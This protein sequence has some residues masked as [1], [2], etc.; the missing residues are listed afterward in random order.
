MTYL[1]ALADE[2]YTFVFQD[3][4]G[5]FGSEGTFE[6]EIVPQRAGGRVEHQGGVECAGA[7]VRMH[8]FCWCPHDD[9]AVVPGEPLLQ[10]R[11]AGRQA[12]QRD[13]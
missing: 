12:D 4:R 9:E 10:C 1:E 13:A 5:K 7:D 8:A 2:G 11:V 6:G 3:I